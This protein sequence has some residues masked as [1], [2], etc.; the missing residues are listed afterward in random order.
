MARSSGSAATASPLLTSQTLSRL[1]STGAAL[2]QQS[3]QLARSAQQISDP[4][5]VP[6]RVAGAGVPKKQ[7]AWLDRVDRSQAHQLKRRV[8]RLPAAAA[9]AATTTAAA[10]LAAALA[11]AT[12]IAA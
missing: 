3:R 5:S 6:L 7:K 11:A 8:G 9:A 2:H 1:F 10:A 4:A 12:F